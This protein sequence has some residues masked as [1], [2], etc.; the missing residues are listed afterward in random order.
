MLQGEER[1]SSGLPP[2]GRAGSSTIRQQVEDELVPSI[3]NARKAPV[4]AVHQGP[5]VSPRADVSITPGRPHRRHVEDGHRSS[6]P[7]D[8][9]G[10]DA[11][12][13]TAVLPSGL[14]HWLLRQFAD[15]L[16]WVA[17]KG[18]AD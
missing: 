14:N 4:A 2:D 3:W 9:V 10:Y 13:L 16:V 8:H 6:H 5:Q 7:R 1:N 15:L 18:R 12:E 11:R 17:G